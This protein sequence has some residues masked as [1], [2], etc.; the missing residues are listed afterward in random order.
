MSELR[1]VEVFRNNQWRR[2]RLNEVKSGEQ[3]RMFEPDDMSPVVLDGKS[4]FIALSDGN[5]LGIRISDD[6]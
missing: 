4:E 5:N 2:C 1:K 3:F 6:K